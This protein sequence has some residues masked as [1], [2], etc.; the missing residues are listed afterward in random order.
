VLN[1]SATVRF[2]EF[3][4]NP[5]PTP[6][7]AADGRSLIFK[8]PTSLNTISCQAGHINVNEWCV[9]IPAN[10]V[11]VDDCPSRGDGLDNFCGKPLPPATYRLS[12]TAAG[13]GISSN[14]V[15]LIVAAPKPSPVS[16]SLLYPNYLVS[17]GDTIT[18]RGHGF[19]SSGNAVQIGSARVTNLS[20]A[21]GKQLHSKHRLRREQ[22]HPWHS[23][24]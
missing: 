13:T 9:P 7:V 8:V 23:N 24:L 14:S 22:F 3:P 17:E 11:D 20:S 1:Q 18:V 4:N 6:I 19:T 5:M 21:D 12:V 16:I 10:H 15:S 2:S